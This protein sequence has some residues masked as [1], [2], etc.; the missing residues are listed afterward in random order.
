MRLPVRCWVHGVMPMLRTSERRNLFAT[1]RTHAHLRTC[2]RQGLVTNS[3]LDAIVALQAVWRARIV[4]ARICLTRWLSA[5]PTLLYLIRGDL[6]YSIY[7]PVGFDLWDRV[8]VLFRPDWVARGLTF[9]DHTSDPEKKEV[10]VRWSV[11]RRKYVLSVDEL[12][13]YSGQHIGLWYLRPRHSCFHTAPRQPCT[14][15]HNKPFNAVFVHWK[16]MTM[17]EE[18]KEEE[19]RSL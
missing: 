15:V 5:Q 1:N 16:K 17:N 14:C 12:T 11:F 13:E 8:Q 19:E 6:I 18:E 4:S 2:M 7:E 9:I 3:E 10:F